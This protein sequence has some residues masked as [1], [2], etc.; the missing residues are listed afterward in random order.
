LDTAALQALVAVAETGSFSLAAERLFITQPATSKRIAALEAELGV[1]LFDRLGRQVRLTEAGNTLLLSARRIL[2]DIATSTDEVKTLGDKVAGKLRLGTSHHIGI[3]RLPPVLKS[4]TQEYTQV[5]LD[6][7]FMDSEL[8]CEEVASGALELAVVTL[9]T[10][11]DHKL[12]TQ[13]I[14]PDPLAIVCSTD[15]PLAG[16]N[17]TSDILA[18]HAAVLPAPG[19]ITRDV[20]FEALSKSRMSV[21]TTLETNYLETIKMMVSV[22]LGWS[23]LPVS[24]MDDSISEIKVRGLKVER[25]LGFVHLKTRT[26]S[27]AANAFL[28]VLRLQ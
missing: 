19:T 7:K 2:S 25:Q 26:L 11:P 9:P 15:H 17:V 28:D 18:D 1:A 12:Q 13:L 24:M 8:A 23:A 16:E 3:H 10:Q 14:W 21:N 5:E 20:L 4:F 22:G 6:L 27:R